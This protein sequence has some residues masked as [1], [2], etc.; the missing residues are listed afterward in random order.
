MSRPRSVA[1]PWYAS[2]HYEALRQSLSDGDKLPIQYEAW[3]AA[4]EQV[5]R[6]V[7]RSGVE[8]VRVPIEP[9]A[10]SAWCKAAGLP[11]DG[12]ARVRYAT[13]ALAS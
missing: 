13:E 11:A 5:E 10:F 3:R 4:T 1:L 7:Q 2:E 9:G 8:V 12:S 6:E